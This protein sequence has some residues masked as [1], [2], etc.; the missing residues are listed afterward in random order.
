[1]VK[2]DMH[3][4]IHF[5]T[6]FQVLCLGLAGNVLRFLYISWLKNPWWVLPFEFMQGEY[7]R[8]RL[9][10]SSAMQMMSV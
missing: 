3:D 5:N 9:T 6:W 4:L 10:G 2:K 8:I 1:M 7:Y